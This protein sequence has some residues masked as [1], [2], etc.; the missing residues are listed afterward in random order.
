MFQTADGKLQK[1]VWRAVGSTLTTSFKANARRRNVW[2]VSFTSITFGRCS[3]EL[4]E[5]VI[6]NYSCRMSARYSGSLHDF[7]LSFGRSHDM[8][9]SKASFLVHT[10]DSLDYDLIRF[11]PGS[12]KH[13]SS[14]GFP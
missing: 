5:M 7:L 1:R 13:I 4:T 9:M 8:R 14:L 6:L 11:K 3:S 2:L 12:N 10:L